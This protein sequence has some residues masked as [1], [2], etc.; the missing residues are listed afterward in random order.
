[1]RGG[2]DSAPSGGARHDARARPT[3]AAADPAPR[4]VPDHRADL[5]L[6]S[7]SCSSAYVAPNLE[8]ADKAFT[9]EPP[10][11]PATLHVR[12]AHDR[13]RDRRLLRRSP[14]SSSARPSASSGYARAGLIVSTVL[15]APLSSSSRARAVRRADTNVVQ[16]IVESLR[17]GHAD[18]ARRDGR[19]VVRTLGRRQHRHRGHDAGR[20]G[21]R[22]HRLRG[23]R[24]RAGH[25]AGCGSASSPRSS[26]AVSIA[27]LHALVIGHASASTRSS[28]VS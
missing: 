25:A 19:A 26:P 12:S 5:R 14:R 27:A 11:I 23:A 17:L 18:R 20:R 6:R 10:P 21:R 15:F 24:R 9:F 8:P 28:P 2:R 3:P 22:L 1:M 13:R 4:P 16:L 7:A